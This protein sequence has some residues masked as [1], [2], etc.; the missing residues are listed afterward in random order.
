MR[1]D[2]E[3]QKEAGRVWN[4]KDSIFYTLINFNIFPLLFKV[5]NV[6]QDFELLL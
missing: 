1:I 5:K 2:K 4:P 6:S 3:F